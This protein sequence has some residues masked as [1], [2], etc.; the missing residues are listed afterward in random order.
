MHV[1]MHDQEVTK[2]PTHIQTKK[3]LIRQDARRQLEGQNDN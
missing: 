1:G 2:K 3:E